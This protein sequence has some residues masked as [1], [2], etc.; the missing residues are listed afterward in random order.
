MRTAPDIAIDLDAAEIENEAVAERRVDLVGFGRRGELRRRPEHSL[1][2]RLAK[3]GGQACPAP[4]GRSRQAART[5]AHCPDCARAA[6]RPSANTI[7]AG[8]TLSCVAAMR[9]SRSR[10]FMAA[11]LRGA[12]DRRRKPAG[13]IAGRDRPGVLGGIDVGDDANVLRLKSEARRRPPAPARCDGPG[14]A[15]SRRPAPRPRRADRD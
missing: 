3:L 6:T 15:A 8:D 9:A 1:A 7:S 5:E 11:S 4:N 2:D 12:G 14:L 10:K 13:I